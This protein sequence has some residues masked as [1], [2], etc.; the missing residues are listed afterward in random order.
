[1]EAPTEK[2]KVFSPLLMLEY[3]RLMTAAQYV[4]DDNSHSGTKFS[5]SEENYQKMMSEPLKTALIGLDY[6]FENNVLT[7]TASEDFL[8]QYENKI[9]REV[10]TTFCNNYKNRYAEYISI[11]E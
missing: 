7:V 11:I 1:M 4:K 3:I 6:R 9:M 10:A 5:I 2:L 8:K